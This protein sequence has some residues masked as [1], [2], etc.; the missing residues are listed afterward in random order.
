MAEKRKSTTKAKLLTVVLV[1]LFLGSCATLIFA[2]CTDILG[3]NGNT[4][5]T[6]PA[7]TTEVTVTEDVTAINTEATLPSTTATEGKEADLYFA[8]KYE[9][10]SVCDENGNEMDLRVAFGNSFREGYVEFDSDRFFIGLTVQGPPENYGGTYNFT[11][12]SEVELRYDNSAIKSA[13]VKA[14][15]DNGIV[16]DV[17]V[18]M[19][20]DYVITCVIS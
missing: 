20:S 2:V 11:S 8:D 13:F 6:E 16:T 7:A 14:F 9:I 19:S 3:I 5:P 4:T 1:V 17:D 15:D 12:D 18:T 10:V